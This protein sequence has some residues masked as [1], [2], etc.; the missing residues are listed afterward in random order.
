MSKTKV[1]LIRLDKIG[2]LI[3]SLPVDQ[4]LDEANYDVTWIIQKGL[5]GVVDLGAKKRKYLELD[6][7]N[8]SV[9]AK[10]LSSFIEEFKPDVAISFQGPWWVNYELFKARIPIRSGVYSQWHSFMFLNKGLRQKRS[11]AIQHEFEYNKDVVLKT[12]ELKDTKRFQYFE[13]VKPDSK[14]ILEKF[15]LT[16]KSY[17]VVHPGMMGSALNW[18][19]DQY[20]G[21][22]NEKILQN[23]VLCITGTASDEPY[24]TK[25]KKAFQN[26]TSVRW[27]QNQL[28]LSE[29]VQILSASEYVVA[30]STGVAHLAASVGALIHGIYSPIKVHHPKR[31]APRGPNVVVHVPE[32]ITAGEELQAMRN[33]R[34]KV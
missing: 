33:L 17:I 34:L 26:H 13:I 25:I 24:L 8:P 28:N 2:D 30:P 10:K 27:L 29:L 4:I 19:Q 23:K 9:S 5:G 18:S 21:F 20:I 16:E 6:K 12:F 7:L 14:N 22:M 3:C 15:K 31:W 1:L 32:N 11:Q